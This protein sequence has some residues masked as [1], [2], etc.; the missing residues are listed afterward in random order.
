MRESPAPDVI[1]WLDSHRT[2]RL[3]VTSVTEAEE[4][5]WDALTRNAKGSE[6]RVDEPL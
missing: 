1:G 6:E 4:C 3:F 2:R 5:R